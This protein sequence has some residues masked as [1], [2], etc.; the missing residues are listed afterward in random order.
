MRLTSDAPQGNFEMMLNYVFSENGQAWLRSDGESDTSIMLT[1]WARRQCITNGCDEFPDGTPEE[2]D[3]AIC[4][5]A[6]YSGE[7]PVFLSYIFACQAVHMRDRCKAY[8]DA[9]PYDRLAEA[10]ELLEA[11]DAQRC[12]NLPVAPA[13]KPLVTNEIWFIDDGVIFSD[14]VVEAVYGQGSNGDLVTLMSTLDGDTLSTADLGKSVFLTYEEAE[15]A[16]GGDTHG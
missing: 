5:C 1:E 2:I 14:H 11:K 16:L 6:M 7:C 12:I 8:E 3:Q 9:I 10:A 15:K 13:L 4:D